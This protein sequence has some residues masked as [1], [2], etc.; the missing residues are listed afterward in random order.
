MFRLLLV[1]VPSDWLLGCQK[2]CFQDSLECKVCL[3]KP[4]VGISISCVCV[5]LL[6]PDS[7]LSRLCLLVV[8]PPKK[9]ERLTKTGLRL[10]KK[11][12]K[13]RA[14]EREEVRILSIS[15]LPIPRIVLIFPLTGEEDCK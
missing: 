7:F 14:K 1:T 2:D 6:L 15:V 8:M 11:L 4:Q 9:D 10:Q 3:V 5:I 13:L 12:D